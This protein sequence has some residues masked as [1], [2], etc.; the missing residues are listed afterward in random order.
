MHFV[1]ALPFL[2]HRHHQNPSP[3]SPSQAIQT[4]RSRT[5]FFLLPT[6]DSHSHFKLLLVY[7][8]VTPTPC[9][10]STWWRVGLPCNSFFQPQCELSDSAITA[11]AM[12]RL[13]SVPHPRFLQPAAA[14]SHRI[15][16]AT[17]NSALATT[18][19]ITNVAPRPVSQ[20]QAC[21]HPLQSFC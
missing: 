9:F 2:F 4:D 18:F 20:L 21:P 11:R 13:L 7:Y 14:G 16:S 1:P 3:V 15:N 8:F 19:C 17:N 5:S 12:P 6:A 10:F